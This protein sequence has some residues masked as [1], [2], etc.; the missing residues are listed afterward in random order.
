[1]PDP[2][3]VLMQS[4]GCPGCPCDVILHVLAWSL[5]FFKVKRTLCVNER[6]TREEVRRERKI[7]KKTTLVTEN[8]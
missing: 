3:A 5:H 2:T 6:G 4:P 8:V 1:M 7:I